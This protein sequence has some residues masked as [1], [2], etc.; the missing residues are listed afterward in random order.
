MQLAPRA[1][2]LLKRVDGN[3]S[4]KPCK[5]SVRY[6]CM[7]WARLARYQCCTSSGQIREVMWVFLCADLTRQSADAT[8]SISGQWITQ[9]QSK[10]KYASVDWPVLSYDCL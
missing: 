3:N 5:N 10:V 9:L 2:T 7:G 8:T 1:I 4:T 6:R